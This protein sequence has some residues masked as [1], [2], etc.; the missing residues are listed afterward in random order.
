MAAPEPAAL[1]SVE[2]GLPLATAL[3]LLGVPYLEGG[4]SPRGFDCSGFVQYVFG[5]HG[6]RLPRTTGEQFS[7]T[8]AI[9]RD[10]ARAGDLVFFRTTSRGPSHVGILVDGQHFVHAPS[11]RGV[12]RV[13]SLAL[14]YWSAR[15]LG[16]RRIPP[17]RQPAA[18]PAPVRP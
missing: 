7:V 1:P 16:F 17:T 15:L 9:T 3:T 11:E 5:A 13:E 2:A 14:P 12:V 6:R 8:A 10:R 4:S 18:A